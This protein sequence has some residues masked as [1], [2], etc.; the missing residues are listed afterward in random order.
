MSN[1]DTFFSLNGVKTDLIWRDGEVIVSTK[2]YIDPILDHVR[3][4]TENRNR[5]ASIWHAGSVPIDTHNQWVRE[6]RSKGLQGEEIKAYCL[7]NLRDFNYKKLR[8]ANI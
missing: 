8:S 5:K 6:A 1:K 4:H 7:K 3:A 2:Q